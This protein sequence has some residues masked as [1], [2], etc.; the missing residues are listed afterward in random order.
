MVYLLLSPK[1]YQPPLPETLSVYKLP[2]EKSG[3]LVSVSSLPSDATVAFAFKS[4]N[5]RGTSVAKSISGY[6][7]FSDGVPS[8][9]STLPDVISA[10]DALNTNTSNLG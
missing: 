10:A 7:G 6:T 3:V 5:F 2:V 4:T 1:V 8:I 9:T